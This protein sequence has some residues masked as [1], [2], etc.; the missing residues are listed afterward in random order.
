M[1]K[2]ALIFA[3][4][5]LL[6]LIILI[7]VARKPER[8][9]EE[10]VIGVIAP[11]SGQYAFLG[12]SERNAML[13]AEADLEKRGI[14]V[15]LIF[16]DDKY[17]AKVG[18]S[19]YEKLKSIDHVDAVIVVSAP[20]IGA[21]KP[22]VERDQMLMLTLG[23]SLFHED[24]TILQLMPASDEIGFRLGEE[25][26][27]RYKRIA[28]AY[29]QTNSLWQEWKDDFI[30]NV[31]DKS[32]VKEFPFSADSDLRTE[33][34]NVLAYAPDA[35]TV[36]LPLQDGVRYLENLNT[37]DAARSVSIICDGNMEFLIN[38]YI[39]KVGSAIFGECIS[40]TLP[41]TQTESFVA[42][43]KAQFDADPLLTADYAYDAVSMLG[44][45]NGKEKGEWVNVLKNGYTHAGA[46][47]K[48]GFNE[49]GTRHADSVLHQYKNGTFVEIP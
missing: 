46:S 39:E 13:M 45:L 7:A 24:D 18:V 40:A 38:E 2:H 5:G 42:E 15:T 28:V 9:Q 41:D 32:E 3:A 44:E 49:V 4:V 1:K 31:G 8:P 20:V 17:D 48:I 12:E 23:E 19:A 14:P 34:Q 16:E 10:L 33:T 27:K 37:Y 6:V 29:S 25:A 47:G 36:F 35:T 11:L 22:L 43:Y 26:A 30:K 21:L